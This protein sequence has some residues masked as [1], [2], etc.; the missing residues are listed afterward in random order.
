LFNVQVLHKL[1]AAAPPKMLVENYM[2][3]IARTYKVPF[4]PDPLAMMVSVSADLFRISHLS[5]I[6]SAY[7]DLIESAHDGCCSGNGD[8]GGNWHVAVIGLVVI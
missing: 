8:G 4:E 7:Y 3:E 2:I 5:S 6:V 1:S